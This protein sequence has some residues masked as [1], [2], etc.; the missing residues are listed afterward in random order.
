LQK[1]RHIIQ[2]YLTSDFLGVESSLE[3][4]FSAI[5]GIPPH[6]AGVLRLLRGLYTAKSCAADFSE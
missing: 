3:F 1:K 6:Y 5:S 2:K 4:L